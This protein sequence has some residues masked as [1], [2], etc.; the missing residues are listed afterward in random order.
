VVLV[1][2]LLGKLRNTLVAAATDDPQQPP[3]ARAFA[4]WIQSAQLSQAPLLQ[5]L[6]AEAAAADGPTRQTAYAAVLG[7]TANLD[8]R[9]AAAFGE[10]LIWLRKRQYF[11]PGRPLTFEVEGLGLL[12]ISVGNTRLDGAQ[13]TAAT[14]W[15]V[16]LLRHS[17]ASRRPSNWNESLIAA[18]LN[19]ATGEPP[20]Q[21]SADLHAALAAKGLIPWGEGVKFAAWDVI[22]SLTGL[23]DGMTRAAAQLSALIF[24]LRATPGC[25]QLK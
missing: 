24:L 7:Y 16:D 21:V 9:F 1:T 18:A 8:T 11:A 14:A 15:L 17:I 25:K 13:R 23:P 4:G 22:A 12:G 5:A 19:I 20:A 2:E 10:A 3:H 6:A